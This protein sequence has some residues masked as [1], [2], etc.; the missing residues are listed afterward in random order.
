MRAS[1]LYLLAFVALLMPG[2][3][4]CDR[5]ATSLDDRAASPDLSRA[6]PAGDMATASAPAP[7]PLSVGSPEAGRTSGAVLVMGELSAAPFA[8]AGALAHAYGS[9]EASGGAV[10][11]L[12]W[13][14]PSTGDGSIWHGTRWEDGFTPLMRVPA[15]W[16][17]AGVGD[18]TGNGSL[19]LVWQHTGTGDRS[20]WHMD[21]RNWTGAYTLLP[22]VVPA[23]RIAA[24]ADFTGNG[25][26]DLVWQHS[27]T[28]DRSIWH[29]NGTG[30]TGSFTLLPRVAVEWQIAGAGDLTGDGKPD[31]VWENTST[32]HRSVWHMDGT[33]WAGGYSLLPRVAVEWRIAGVGDFNGD[34][35]PDLVWQNTTT[36]QR[37]IWFMN[38]TSYGGSY[39]LLHTVDPGWHIVAVRTVS[40]PPP[41]PPPF[42]FVEQLF[43]YLLNRARH[44]PLAYQI[45]RGLNVDL[46][47][48]DPRPPLA[49]NSSLHGS[50]R[51]HAEE[52]AKFNYFAHQSQVTGRWPN[53]NARDHGYPLPASWS[54]DANNIESIAAGNST[55]EATLEQL[56]LSDGHRNH[57]LGIHP[58]FAANREAGVGYGHSATSTYR[59]YW[60]VHLARTEPSQTF[61]T[62][63]V[64]D[65]ANGN[66]RY[67][68][69]EG[70]G[71]VTVT[72]GNTTA[73]TN[74][75]G[76]WVVAVPPNDAYQVTVAGA[77]FHG[78]ATASVMVANDNRQV[79]FISG[80]A[81][82]ILDFK[83]LT[84]SAL[85]ASPP[86][87]V[88]DRHRPT[89]QHRHALHWS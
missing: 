38:G 54:D 46:S 29:M 21:G 87:A 32:G 70:L 37:S 4:G 34:S 28:G 80:Q 83:P 1:K 26:P 76:G 14:R 86:G 5:D 75:A 79:D 72:V 33:N 40:A 56:V 18:F 50:A 89:P 77:G 27:T 7:G 67:D 62:G 2:L 15:G 59:H 64:F 10:P 49:I 11:D 68:L 16:E 43:V 39:Q 42:A 74:A 88:P 13:Q 69:N 17:I 24:V 57:L 8:G 78:T 6:I 3:A 81:S 36:G 44:D 41:T 23:W 48:V 12:V 22:R 84:V 31:L 19:D 82:G 58:F 47:S 71:G 51:F 61:L 65:D 66:G 60:A 85:T 20:I 25:T 45:E 73:V 53:R 52:M 63:V 55:A 35:R 30:W 9:M